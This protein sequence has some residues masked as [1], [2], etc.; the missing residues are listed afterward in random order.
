MNVSRGKQ[1]LPLCCL[2][3]HLVSI[4]LG[5]VSLEGSPISAQENHGTRL[6]FTT[7]STALLSGMRQVSILMIFHSQ[8]L[9]AFSTSKVLPR[10]GS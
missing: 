2:S 9:L 5:E 6:Q 3:P 4:P 7:Y 1:Y 10:Q 8:L